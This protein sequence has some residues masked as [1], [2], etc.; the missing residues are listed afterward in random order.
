MNPAFALTAASLSFAP[1][2]AFAGTVEFDFAGLG[3]PGLTSANEVGANTPMSL[4]GVA[5]SAFGSEFGEGLV[6]DTGSNTLNFAFA[7]SQLSGGLFDAATGIHLHETAEG[8]DPFSSTGPIVFNLNNFNPDDAVTNTNTL[9][10]AGSG[11]GDGAVSGAVTGSLV[12]TDLQ[13]Q[14][15][16]DGRFYLNIHSDTFRGGELRGNLVASAAAAVPTP[17]AAGLGLSMLGLL[18]CRRCRRA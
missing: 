6:L 14:S 16:L 15:L 18:S 4:P 5:T 2:A 3:G 8:A 12:L 17:A 11:D 13:E 7:F 1:G 10:F 9:I